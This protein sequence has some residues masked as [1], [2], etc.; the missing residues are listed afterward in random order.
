MCGIH[1]MA[2]LIRKLEMIQRRAARFCHHNTSSVDAMLI[3][4]AWPTL[5]RSDGNKPASPCSTVYKIRNGLVT[6]T[7]PQLVDSA[8]RRRRA[9][10]RT[11]QRIPCRTDYRKYTASCHAPSVIGTVFPMTLSIPCLLAP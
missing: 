7:Y 2:K 6:G 3:T 11:H 1:I 4:L 10:D 8:G 9:H 5:Q